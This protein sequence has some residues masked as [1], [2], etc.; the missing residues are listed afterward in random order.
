MIEG[1]AFAKAAFFEGKDPE[2][3]KFR[4]LPILHSVNVQEG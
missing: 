4:G 3:V 1:G 2:F